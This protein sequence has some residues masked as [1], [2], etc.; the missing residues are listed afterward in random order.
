MLSNIVML[1]SLMAGT[2][3]LFMLTL[4]SVEEILK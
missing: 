4:F 2:A 1:W 3:I